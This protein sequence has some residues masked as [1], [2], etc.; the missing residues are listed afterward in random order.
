MDKGVKETL[1]IK[2][3]ISFKC[4]RKLSSYLVRANIYTLL[5]KKVGS[6]R[7]NKKCYELHVSVNETRTFLLP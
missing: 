6:C 1:P 2:P 5:K 3:M 4:S 7:C